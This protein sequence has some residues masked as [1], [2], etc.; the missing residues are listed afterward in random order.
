[1]RAKNLI[2]SACF[3]LAAFTVALAFFIVFHFY[4]TA[5]AITF[6][7]VLPTLAGMIGGWWVGA[8]ILNEDRTRNVWM[9]LGWG[10]LTSFVSYVLFPVL[11]AIGGYLRGP[12]A[13]ATIH[14]SPLQQAYATFAI[15]L[16]F[17]VPLALPAGMITGA[18]L[19]LTRRRAAR[20]R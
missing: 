19:Y 6:Y 3:G 1:V 9:A 15:G 11:F 10:A 18:L 2:A 13:T 12:A 4:F 16:L 7:L 8:S 17:A 14:S 20:A 5:L